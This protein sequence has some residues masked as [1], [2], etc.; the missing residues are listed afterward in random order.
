[1]EWG[2]W[3]ARVPLLELQ[4][5]NAVQQTPVARRLDGI[6]GVLLAPFWEGSSGAPGWRLISWDAEQGICLTFE[7]EGACVLLEL[8][9]RNER[10][11]CYARTASFNICA[12]RQ[13]EDGQLTEAE[14]RL[15]DS[16]VAVLREREGLLP[17]RERPLADRKTVVREI[18]VDRLLIPE[19][20]RHYYINPYVGCMIACPFCY[21]ID[22]A[23][24]SRALE[25]L[26]R[27]PWGQSLDVKV[28]AAEVLRRETRNVGTGVVR[29]SPILTDPYQPAERRYHITRQCLQVL[30]DT[31]LAPVVLT[32]A[33]RI[34]EDL[35]LF[36]RFRRTLVG[37]SIPTDAEEYRRIFEPRADPI[38]ARLQA[39]RAFHAAGVRTFA[40]IQPVLPMN[41]NRL[42][43]EVAPF[44]QVVRLDR[45]YGDRVQH[46]YAEHGLEAFATQAYAEETIRRLAAA[47]GSRG[48]AVD[49]LNDLERLLGR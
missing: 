33:P 28:N 29:M 46:L 18:L 1:M 25:G 20:R 47:F 45:M 4:E 15:V 22:R 9:E 40:V 10:L 41:V 13:F 37:F 35:E 21:V 24:F 17:R 32:R 14:R 36:T 6:V 26:P 7:R 27:L 43:D 16:V 38:E 48:V 8:E 12:R 3:D 44:V 23:D 31:D 2:G 42:V 19:G 49:E 39:L 34:V 30:L 11:D 5:L